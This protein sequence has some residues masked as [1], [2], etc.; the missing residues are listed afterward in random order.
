MSANDGLLDRRILLDVLVN[1][2]PIGILAFFVL[3]FIVY[4]PYPSDPVVLVIQMSL[5]IIPGV[6][7]AIVTYYT[8]RVVT[9][10]ERDGGAKTPPGYSQDDA[11][12]VDAR[13]NE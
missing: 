13:D 5:I 10:D 3:L 11:E 12:T 9:R 2:V 4:A 7:V 6:V 8:V 1:L